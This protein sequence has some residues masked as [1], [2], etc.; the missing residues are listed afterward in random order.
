[1]K[2][3]KIKTIVI[4]DEKEDMDL[5]L[6]L[7]K[8]FSEIEVAETARD[9][10]EGIT[11]VSFYKP[12]LIFLDINLYG[13]IS[14]EI[15]D[16]IYKFNIKP[17]VIFTTA[18]DEF[19]SRAFKY[20]AFDYLLKP[21]DRAELGE[22]IKRFLN[23]TEQVEFPESYR[24]FMSVKRKLVFN[25]AEGFEVAEPDEICYLSTVKNK[26]YTEIFMTDGSKIVVSKHI[27]EVYAML[28]N[29]NFFKIHRSYV[30]NIKYIKKINRLK[31]KCYIKTE[32]VE[33][34]IPASRE[35]IK[36]LKEM[37]TDNTNKNS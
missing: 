33:Y 12:D 17:K 1:M 30:I 29:K 24:R 25:T 32:N 8:S 37:L 28:Q 22:T 16:V 19:M 9:I 20:S 11:A 5:M 31:G 21:V 3:N 27:G 26:S 14:F 15:L 4:E 13:R 2:K 34:E 36:K 7:L 10:D 23:Q 18:F 6:N 35:K